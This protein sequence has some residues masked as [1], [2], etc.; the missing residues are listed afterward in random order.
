MGASIENGKS[1]ANGQ[2]NNNLNSKSNNNGEC[3]DYTGRAI[4]TGMHFV[5]AGVD[6]CRLCICENGQA[7]V[8]VEIFFVI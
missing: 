8:N 2:V 7:K 6:M 3:R 4:Q 1:A 5:P